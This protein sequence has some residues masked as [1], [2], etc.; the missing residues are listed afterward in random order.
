[1]RLFLYFNTGICRGLIMLCLLSHV[2][3]AKSQNKADSLKSALQLSLKQRATYKT[4]F[5]QTKSLSRYYESVFEF[6]SAYK[7]YQ[8]QAQL[9]RQL[10]SDDFTKDSLLVETF[11]DIN[12][13]S[14]NHQKIEIG[15]AYGDSAIGLSKKRNLPNKL[16]RG[17][18]NKAILLT[19]N[20]QF[21]EAITHLLEA[22]S[23]VESI[24][25]Q[26]EKSALTQSILLNIGRNYL[27]MED[28]N[29]ALTYTK[30]AL[31]TPSEHIRNLAI[32]NLN[33][34]AIFL[35][36][37]K[38]DSAISYA[39]AADAAFEELGEQ[40]GLLKAKINQASCYEKALDYEKALGAY[41]QTLALAR[42]IGDPGSEALSLGGKGAVLGKM[43]RHT[44]ALKPLHEALAL[45]EKYDDK[46]FMKDFCESLSEVYARMNDFDNAY[47]YYTRFDLLND[48]IRSEENRKTVND[49]LIKY[50]TA[51]KEQEI[52]N[53]KLEIATK[54]SELSF[55]RFQIIGLVAGIAILILFGLVF[56]NQYKSKQERQFQAAIL[57]EKEKGFESIITATEEERNR[58]SKDLHDG[59]GQQLSALKMALANVS[60]KISDEEQR[61]DL[62]MITAQFGKSADEV[63]QISHQM[64]P[65]S[66]MEAGLIEAIEGLLANAFQFSEITY[67]FEHHKADQR[68]DARIEISLYRIVQELINNVIKHAQATEVAVQLMKTKGKL[69]LFLEDNGK[70]FSSKSSSQGHGLLNIKSRLDMVK[71]TVNYEPSPTTGTSA[72]ITIPINE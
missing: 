68:F 45:A 32:G 57:R 51:Q 12:Y 11:M 60:G 58:I 34:S 3:H 46:P 9:M 25:D 22:R 54:E 5:E 6:D 13:V 41:N 62:E 53:Q 38:P 23:V 4:V 18:S 66:L 33:V 21:Q 67:R 1:M 10:V 70:G 64:M 48:S 71:G 15:I 69:V 44:S 61:E 37:E 47:K 56:Y 35:K 14:I 17:L 27:M 8:L 40:F 28:Y 50:Q 36:M 59:I 24:E 30:E 55:K 26:K 31:E 19:T 29:Q 43:G 7:Y 52:A 20:S 49:L 63:R 2:T 72:T 16:S 39:I 42:S 65:R